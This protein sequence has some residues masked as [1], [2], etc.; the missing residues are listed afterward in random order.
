L[1]TR[2]LRCTYSWLLT[3]VLDIIGKNKSPFRMDAKWIR[4]SS[5]FFRDVRLT[6]YTRRWVWRGNFILHSY[7]LL[8]AVSGNNNFWTRGRVKVVCHFP[9]W[10]RKF[11]V[12]FALGC[13]STRGRKFH[14]T[15]VPGSE[16]SR[17]RKFHPWNFRS[18]KYVG[19]LTA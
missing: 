3:V 15:K 7:P 4:R 18:R 11:Y 5:I 2:K 14:G 16:S 13:E 10:E 1:H 17:E 8:S 6:Y 19:T 12:I 9:L